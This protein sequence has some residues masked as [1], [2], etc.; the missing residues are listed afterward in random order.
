MF[1]KLIGLF[2]FLLISTTTAGLV[3]EFSQSRSRNLTSIFGRDK[4][5]SSVT[6][7]SALRSAAGKSAVVPTIIDEPIRRKLRPRL[8]TT[9]T[10]PL[11]VTADS[12]EV[13]VASYQPSRPRLATSQS[14]APITGKTTRT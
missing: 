7:V 9:G 12:S 2:G 3:V 8:Y 5:V 6:P 1:L 13:T 14:P 10:Q 4:S 11:V